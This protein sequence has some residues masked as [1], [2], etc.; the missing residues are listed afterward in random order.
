[1]RCKKILIKF[2]IEF[3]KLTLD[4]QNVEKNFKLLKDNYESLKNE[5]EELKGKNKLLTQQSISLSD[6]MKTTQIEI[7]KAVD[8][9]AEFE[10]TVKDSITWFKENKNIENFENYELIKKELKTCLKSYD[11]CKKHA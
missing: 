10:N 11:T 3:N 9:L 5:N 4:L 8:K 2:N 6:E 7:D 1:M